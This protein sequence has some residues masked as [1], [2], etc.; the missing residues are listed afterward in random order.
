MEAFLKSLV[1]GLNVASQSAFE[2][3]LAIR[4]R[5]DT[6]GAPDPNSDQ[7]DTLIRDLLAAYR[8]LDEAGRRELSSGLNTYAMKQLLGYAARS[9]ANAVQSKS[10]DLVRSGLLALAIE[11]GSEDP[12]ESTIVIAMLYHSSVRLGMEPI[13]TFAEAAGFALPGI[14]NEILR[15][16]LREPESRDLSAFH[17]VEKNDPVCGFNYET[18]D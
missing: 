6:D 9:A 18:G 7:V 8:C 13:T 5:P 10:Q 1:D 15:F 2:R 11:G 4:N 3:W 12:R 16:P 17:L 14:K